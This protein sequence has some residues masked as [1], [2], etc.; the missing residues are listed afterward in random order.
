[1]EP[2]P[3]QMPEADAGVTTPP[4]LRVGVVAIV[5]VGVALTLS[6]TLI[7]AL[8]LTL[9]PILALT[10]LKGVGS[11]A[12]FYPN[13][14]LSPDPNPRP[15]PNL[16]EGRGQLG[17]LLDRGLRLRVLVRVEDFLTLPALECDRGKLV[18]ELARRVRRRPLLL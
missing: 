17:Q 13:P 6:L 2:A 16:L 14:S 9:T 3:S 18:G 7:L 15:S 1:M 12:S 11:L 5:R 10:F 4:C 8:A